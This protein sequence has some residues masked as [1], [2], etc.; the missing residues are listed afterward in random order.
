MGIIDL[1]DIGATD[2]GDIVDGDFDV[3]VRAAGVTKALTPA[4]CPLGY[5]R[6]RTAQK[7]E[8]RKRSIVKQL[9]LISAIDAQFR[10]FSR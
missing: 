8:W 6:N 7:G 9:T 1:I 10:G 5:C 4:V 3:I 2:L